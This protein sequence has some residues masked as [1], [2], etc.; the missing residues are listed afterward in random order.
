[1]DLAKAFDTVNHDILL[2]KLNQYGIRGLAFDLIKSYLQHR[3]QIVQVES[4]LSSISGINIGVPQGSAL[5]PLFF[6]IYINDLIYTSD[7]KVTL[8]ADDSVFS[9]AHKNIDFLQK[10]LDQNLQKEDR[11]LKNNQ[12]SV[13]VDKTKFLLFATSNKTLDVFIKRSKI[14]QTK[15]IKYLE[16][17]IDDKLKW[18]EHID[19][20]ANKLSAAREILCK[21]RRNVP[22]NALISVYEL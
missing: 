15:S 11:W 12:L 2:Y 5:G 16:V 10:S 19:Y 3:K 7:L 22:Q 21:L 17:L 1:M 13:N 9:L 14:E 6:L 18:H 4:H 20:V 8:Y